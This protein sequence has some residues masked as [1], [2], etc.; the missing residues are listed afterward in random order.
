MYSPFLLFEFSHIWGLFC[1]PFWAI[2]GVRVR[3]KTFLEPNNVDINFCFWSETLFFPFLIQP[4]LGLF[5]TFWALLGYFW[6]WGQVQKLYYTYLCTQSFSFW[7]YSPI[8]LVFNS[9]KFLWL[10]CTLL[11]PA[12]LLFVLWDYIWGWESD[13]RTFL[14]FSNV[15]YQ[16]LFWKCSPIF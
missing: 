2:F 10:F 9:A 12:G 16:F 14:E 15:D 13:S 1:R 5:S 7:K 11:G 6:G 3:L 8:F 4:N